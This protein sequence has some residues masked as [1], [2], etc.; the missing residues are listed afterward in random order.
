MNPLTFLPL[1]SQVDVLPDAPTTEPD[2]QRS[3]LLWLGTFAAMVAPSAVLGAMAGSYLAT[4]TP[5]QKHFARVGAA[6]GVVALSLAMMVMVGQ[7]NA[8]NA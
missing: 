5:R 3:P 1:M 7:Q 8:R 4:V 6:G 2:V